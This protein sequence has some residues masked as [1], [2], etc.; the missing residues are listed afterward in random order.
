M[1]SRAKKTEISEDV[2]EQHHKHKKEFGNTRQPLINGLTT[3]YDYELFKE[4]QSRAC[5]LLVS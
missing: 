4:A 5:E 2:K 3:D 1:K